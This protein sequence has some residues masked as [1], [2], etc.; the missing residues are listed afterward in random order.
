VCDSDS[1]VQCVPDDRR[2]WAAGTKGND[3]GIHVELCGR[4][5][6]TAAEWLDPVSLAGLRLASR[7]VATLC[8]RHGLPRQFVTAEE[9]VRGVKGIT[10]H[11]EIR[12]AW[13]QTTHTDP[14]ASFPMAEFMRAVQMAG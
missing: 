3:L 2:S 13:K 1:I 8:K 12:K 10:T 5:K 7:L 14:G 6:Q 4:A 11:D 9:L